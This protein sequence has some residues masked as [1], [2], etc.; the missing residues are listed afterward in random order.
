MSEIK[1]GD[2]IVLEEMNEDC[3]V[4]NPGVMVGDEFRVESIKYSILG[5]TI[6]AN[7]VDSF[8]DES[9]YG[10]HCFWDSEVVKRDRQYES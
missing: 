1:V 4:F 3:N 7:W 6:G 10:E 8:G 9:V 2:I 5:A